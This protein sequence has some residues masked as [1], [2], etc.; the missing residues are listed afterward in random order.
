MLIGYATVLHGVATI[1]SEVKLNYNS[2]RGRW[3]VG[4]CSED[5]DVVK[6]RK[7]TNPKG[8]FYPSPSLPL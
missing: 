6:K 3:F 5:T 4:L 1:D 8:K 2:P 7:T